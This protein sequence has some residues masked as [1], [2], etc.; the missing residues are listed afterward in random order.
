MASLLTPTWR[1]TFDEGFPAEDVGTVHIAPAADALTFARAG[2][3]LLGVVAYEAGT[4]KAVDLTKRFGAGDAVEVFNREGYAKIEEAVSNVAADDLVEVP[5]AD[6]GLAVDFAGAH[7]AVGTNYPEHAKDAGTVRPFLFPKL[8]LPLPSGSTVGVRGGLLDYEAE[9]ALVTLR[10]LRV[11]QGLPESVGLVLA[12]DFTDRDLL[13]RSLDPRD[14][15][16]GKGFTTG[17][18]APDYLP[19]GNLLVV[20]RDFRSFIPTLELRL[21]VNGRLRQRAPCSE[22]VWSADEM[23]R[24]ALALQGRTWSHR[25]QQVPLFPGDAVPE[26]TMVLTGT[27]H[28]TVFQGLPPAVMLRGLAGFLMGGFLWQGPMGCA[29]DAYGDA[30]RTGGWYLKAGDEVRV[31]VH[32]LGELLSLVVE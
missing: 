24:Q 29:I 27:P 23:L 31:H 14:I 11:G 13:F 17:K 3:T 25:G 6:L 28:G 26:R 4:V 2:D 12:N 8:G 7:V 30:A 15:L 20:P 32:G 21:Y 9:L 5:A 22:M 19:A 16:S 1:A 18:S 10:P